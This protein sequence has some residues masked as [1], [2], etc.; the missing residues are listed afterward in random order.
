MPIRPGR[1]LAALNWL[2]DRSIEGADGLD[3]LYQ[4]A[5]TG[6]NPKILKR[7]QEYQWSDPELRE[8]YRTLEPSEL[9]IRD[10]PPDMVYEKGFDPLDKGFKAESEKGYQVFD[11]W[12]EVL[13]TDQVTAVEVRYDPRTAN[14]STRA[15]TSASASTS[16]P[17]GRGRPFP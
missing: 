11:Q 17:A 14:R 12:I 7:L 3:D 10:V 4:P 8:R 6:E 15:S 16:E 9:T 5:S 2:S 13:P 1:E